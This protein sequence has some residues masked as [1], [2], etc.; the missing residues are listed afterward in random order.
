MRGLFARGG[1]VEKGRY[2]VYLGIA[3]FHLSLVTLGAAKVDYGALP[4]I[5]RFLTF[6]GNLTGSNNSYGF[7]SPGVFDQLRA[8]FEVIDQNGKSQFVPLES[9]VSHEADLRVGNII[10]QLQND[11]D[12]DKMKFQRSL[13]R[14]LVGT[15]FG[16][17]PEAERVTVYLDRF[18]TISMDEY[19]KGERPKWSPVYQATFIHKKE[20]SHES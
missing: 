4:K 15:I 2:H 17:Y 5:G 6:Y 13:S 7:F 19:R 18:D 8:R 9:G 10:D 20:G 12:D 1:Q 16:R 3:V 11:F 14:S